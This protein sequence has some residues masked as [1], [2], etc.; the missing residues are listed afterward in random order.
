MASTNAM[1]RRARRMNAS[2]GAARRRFMPPS[3]ARVA[4]A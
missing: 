3:R 4:A 2:D 1:E